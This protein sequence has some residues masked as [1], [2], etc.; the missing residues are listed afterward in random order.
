MISA[1]TAR[2]YSD[3]GKTALKEKAYTF[4]VTEIEPD[5]IRQTELGNYSLLTTKRLDSYAIEFLESWGYKVEHDDGC[6][7]ISWYWKDE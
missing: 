4:L 1:R 2:E 6:Y 3:K 5:V 7:S